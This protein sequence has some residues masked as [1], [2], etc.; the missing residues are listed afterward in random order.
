[1]T[2]KSSSSFQ[3]ARDEAL[4]ALVLRAGLTPDQVSA[5]RLDQVHLATGTLVVE[6][7][8]FAPSRSSIGRSLSLKL[9]REVQRALIA[10]LVVRPDGPNDHLFPGEGAEG[11][12]VTTIGQVVAAPRPSEPPAEA[13]G[14]SA[15]S[16]AEREQVPESPPEPTTQERRPTAERDEGPQAAVPLDEIEALRKRLAEVYDAWAPAAPPG[17]VEPVARPAPEAEA[18][19]SPPVGPVEPEVPPEPAVSPPVEETYVSAPEEEPPSDVVEPAPAAEVDTSVSALPG[20]S[21]VAPPAESPLGGLGDRVK[22]WLE[23]G[24]K[25]ITLNLSYR[26]VGIGGLALVIVCCLGLAVAGGVLFRPGGQGGLVAGATPTEKSTP[27][28]TT[29]SATPTPSPSPTLSAT[30]VSTA[31]VSA[32]ATVASAPTEVPTP[33]PTVGPTPTPIVIVVTATPTPEPPATATPAPPTDTPVGGAPSEPA[34]TPTPAFKYP[35]PVLLEPE[36]G[37]VVPGVYA[38]LKWEPVGPLADDEW[39]AVRLIY[40]QQGEPVYQGDRVK[41]TEWRVPE[42]FYYQADGPALEYHW[43]VF[44]ERENPDGSTT[45]LSPESETF[46]FRWE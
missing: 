31:V 20:D 9:D 28:E 7:E 36:D 32:T 11:L 42:R 40:L 5:L 13:A 21:R 16:V 24:E 41:V 2:Q 3:A 17:P 10:W 23:S 35:A 39:Y 45:Q 37:G 14:V 38:F 12:D 15:P 4:R 34:A 18:P 8:E 6:P 43:Y 19:P 25:K 33:P 22:G 26:A 44:V 29:R 30:A 46:V 27:I 1:M